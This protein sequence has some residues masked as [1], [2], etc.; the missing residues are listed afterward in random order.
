MITMNVAKLLSSS[1]KKLLEMIGS[2]TDESDSTI[3]KLVENSYG[4][5]TCSDAAKTLN[6]LGP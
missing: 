5:N 4:L 1:V 6:V 2:G 3:R